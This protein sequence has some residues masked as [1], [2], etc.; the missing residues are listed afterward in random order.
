MCESEECEQCAECERERLFTAARSHRQTRLA[1]I[2]ARNGRNAAAQHVIRNGRHPRGCEAAVRIQHAFRRRRWRR[3][4]RRPTRCRSRCSGL[5]EGRPRA[6]PDRRSARRTN[7]A[8]VVRGP[9]LFCLGLTN[10]CAF[11]HRP[12]R[13]PWSSA[14]CWRPSCQLRHARSTARRAC[15][16]RRSVRPP[17]WRCRPRVELFC[18]VVAMGSSAARTPSCA[19][20]GT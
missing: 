1:K 5:C 11:G 17:T 6:R 12:R 18:K 9:Q 4:I 10:C 19:T 14:W 2:S 13:G 16:T 20:A 3:M 7:I 8:P 15:L